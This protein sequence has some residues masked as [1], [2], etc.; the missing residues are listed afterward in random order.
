MT[1][2]AAIWA[3]AAIGAACGL[4]LFAIATSLFV[5]VFAMLWVPWTARLVGFDNGDDDS[6]ELDDAPSSRLRV[7]T[8]NGDAP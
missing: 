2:A 6:D 8:G 1:T 5:V 4:G 3:A 7:G